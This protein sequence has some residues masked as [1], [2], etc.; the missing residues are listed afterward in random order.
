MA[1]I[2]ARG[3]SFCVRWRAGRGA[4]QYCCTFASYGKALA[5]K[6]LAEAHDHRLS[7]TEVYLAV[8]PDRLGS[9]GR[10]ATPPLRDWIEQWL[11]LKIDV[12]PRTH[13]EYA[14]ILRRSVAPQLGHVHVGDLS[15]DLHLN[16]WKAQLAQ[17]LKP[18]TVRKHWTVLHQVMRDAVPR[19]RPDNPLA[20]PPGQRGNGLPRLI[21]Y[22]ARFLTPQEAEIL[23]RHCPPECR[24]VVQAALGTGMRLGELLG[25][26]AGAVVLDADRP[27]IYVETTLLADGT[28]GEPKSESSR[29]AVLLSPSMVVLFRRLTEGLRPDELIFTTPT[30]LPWN[31]H[32]LRRRYW[33]PAVA[34]ATTCLHHANVPVDRDA[35]QLATSVSESACHCVDRLHQTLRFQDLRHTHVGFLI[36]AG[37]DFYAVQ[38]RLGH[39]SI[40]TTFDIY[41]HRLPHGE[42]TGLR[43]LDVRLPDDMPTAPTLRK[44]G[45]DTRAREEPA[46]RKH[47]N[48]AA[49][50][51]QRALRRKASRNASPRP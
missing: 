48:T 45:G 36:D 4:K 37:W 5:A 31:S 27:A 8:D 23:V 50:S 16:P 24:G 3:R 29:R 41:G 19:Y 28:I 12:A 17:R 25:L 26:Y 18:A 6:L 51:M 49:V 46:R 7:S 47:R 42:Q 40:K 33:R 9:S 34:A 21:K 15:R 22:R 2:I 44:P 14:R 13:T 30:G 10:R 11:R 1:C 20:R 32:N 38:L 43:A 35:G 39:A